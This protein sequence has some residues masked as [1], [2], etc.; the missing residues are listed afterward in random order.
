MIERLKPV[1]DAVK[2]VLTDK[3]IEILKNI[4]IKINV[5]ISQAHLLPNF[6]FVMAI[7]RESADYHTLF[8]NLSTVFW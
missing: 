4:L 7:S 6:A 1:R 2:R 8:Y 5:L 3:I